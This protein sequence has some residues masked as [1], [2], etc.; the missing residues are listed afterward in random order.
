VTRTLAPLEFYD[1]PRIHSAYQRARSR[2]DEPNLTLE[3]PYVLDYLGDVAGQVVLDLGCGAAVVGAGLL[4]AGARSYAG[5]DGSDRMIEQARS[6]LAAFPG[7]ATVE[8]ADLESWEP[9]PAA[10]YDAVLARMSL[11]YVVDLGGLLARVRGACADGGRLVL[12]VEHPVVTCSYDA[13]WDEDAVP[14]VW[15][16]H[17]YFD[18]GPRSCPWLDARVVKQHRTLETYF[19]LLQDAGFTPDRISEGTPRSE[20]FTETDVWRRR[21]AVPMY[22]MIRAHAAPRETIQPCG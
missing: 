17:G 2:V 20:Q 15:R 16:V 5:V 18:E 8:Q 19:R 3:E 6:A 10:A 11:H 21:R 13:D 4:R 22:L 14:R 9:E 12:S 7:R 1:E